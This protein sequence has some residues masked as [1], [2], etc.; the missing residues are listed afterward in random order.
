MTKIREWIS[1]FM[2]ADAD[3]GG[4][5]IPITEQAEKWLMEFVDNMIIIALSLI[6]IGILYVLLFTKF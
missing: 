6:V 1:D 5:G 2:F 4:I 3:E